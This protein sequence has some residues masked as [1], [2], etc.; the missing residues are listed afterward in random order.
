MTKFS[1]S[2]DEYVNNFI[3]DMQG[4]WPFLTVHIVYN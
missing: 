3:G 1:I 2:W 4:N